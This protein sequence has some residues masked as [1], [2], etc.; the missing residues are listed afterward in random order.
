MCFIYCGQSNEYSLTQLRSELWFE[1]VVCSVHPSLGELLYALNL[2]LLLVSMMPYQLYHAF[3]A[4][5]QV[6]HTIEDFLQ[7][8]GGYYL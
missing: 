7:L 6:Q 2:G 5:S 3:C 8:C 1:S 4:T